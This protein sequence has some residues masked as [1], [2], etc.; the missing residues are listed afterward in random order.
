MN[1][2]LDGQDDSNPRL[3]VSIKEMKDSLYLVETFW[4]QQTE[5]QK[6]RELY[7][8]MKDEVRF[9]ELQ[10]LRQTNLLGIFRVENS[11]IRFSN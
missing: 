3:N 8:K 5:N 6:A 4:L 1:E 2:N 7:L 9:I 10:N 11:P